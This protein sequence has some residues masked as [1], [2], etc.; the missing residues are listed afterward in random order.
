MST[1]YIRL[2]PTCGT[3]NEA[4]VMRCACGALLAGVDLR[5][6]QIASAAATPAPATEPADKPA[7]P[8]DTTLVCSYEDCGQSNPAG[9]LACLYCN[10]LLTNCSAL[11]TPES[12]GLLSLPAALSERYRILKPLPV[13]GAEAELLLVRAVGGGPTLVA[14]IY[15]RGIQPKAETQE[16]IAKVN[17]AHRVELLEHGLSEGHAF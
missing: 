1:D 13:T 3:E 14:K 10:R 11:T 16:R 9:S 8:S 17:P 12:R 7:K 6:K 5:A 4:D 15:R 2:C